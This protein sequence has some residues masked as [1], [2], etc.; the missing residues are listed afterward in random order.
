MGNLSAKYK[1]LKCLVGGNREKTGYEDTFGMPKEEFWKITMPNK[2]IRRALAQ[3]EFAIRLSRQLNGRYHDDVEAA[4][5]YMQAQIDRDGVLTR[6]TCEKAEVFLLPLAEEAKA[7]SLILAAHAHIDMNWM[8]SW[9]ETVAATIATFQ[10][11]LQLLEEYPDFCF[12][13]S[14]ASVYQIVEK[15]APELKEKIQRY[16]QEGR[17][18][19]TASAWVETDK[20]M[21]STES[22]LNHIYYTKKYMQENWGIPPESLNI[23][24][25]PDTFGH[26][27]NLPELD[28][29]G[30]VDYYYHCRGLDGDNALYRWRAPSGKEMIVYREQYW[31]NS[32]ITPAPGIGIIDVANRSGGL[33]TGLVVY[34][35]GDHGGGPTRRDLERAL[36]MM[37]WPVFPAVRFGTI[38]EFFK[39]AE[40]V[41][42]LLPLLD[43]ELNFIMPGCYTTQSRLKMANRRTEAALFDAQ[44]WDT[45]AKGRGVSASDESQFASA[46]QN[47][48]FTH[49]H[50]I[51]TGSCVQDTREHAM[52][53][54]SEATA[55]AE[56]RA[57]LALQGIAGLIDTSD[58]AVI[59]QGGNQAD[60][61]GAG[62]GVE[63]F[64]GV[65]APERG[66]GLTRIYHLFNSASAAREEA[67]EITVWD[68][69]GDMREIVFT[70]PHGEPLAFQLLDSSL[71]QYWDHKYFRVLVYV[72]IP[73]FGY[74][75]V[76][77]AEKEPEE[78]R[79]YFQPEERSNKPT[80]DM[81]LQNEHLRAVFCHRTGELLSLVDNLTGEEQVRPGLSGGLRL[82]QTEKA[83]SN[84]W[85]IG[86]YESTTGPL[87]T[88]GIKPFA[89]E[90][91]SGFELKQ[92]V[93]SSEITTVV[94]LSE[95]AKALAL[96]ITADWHEITGETVPVLI[97]TVPVRDTQSFLYDVPGGA[98]R[99]DAMELDVPGLQYAAAL[100]GE[101]AL[102][103]VSD[104]KYGY[105]GT[106]DSLS[107]TLINATYS[108][109]P[110]PE[111]GIHKIKLFLGMQKSCPKVL[112]EM[113]FCLNH[114]VPYQSGCKKTGPLGKTGALLQAE[115]GT[116]VL[117][118]ISMRDGFITVRLY[119]TCGETAIV[120]LASDRIDCS[121]AVLCDL[122]GRPVN[123]SLTAAE[124][125]IS[126]VMEPNSTKM[127]RIPLP[128]RA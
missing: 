59:P 35:V 98:Q 74:T 4:L 90:L 115:L 89:G 50:D 56:S 75:T 65:P 31:Y 27:A 116:A 66:Q 2:Y 85:Q 49:F 38:G 88:V 125:C 96:D 61:A 48:L 105:R 21:P 107:C 104:C 123:G 81:V 122:M 124:D 22:L 46:W 51:L 17:W 94:S 87:Q 126:L 30:G 39:E 95:N 67:C 100:H 69:T 113:A 14:Q 93:Q 57:S 24:F 13:Q 92:K 32:G 1:A 70:G 99:R 5:D 103:L 114:P 79:I 3:T 11:M 6:E 121:G 78:Y 109:D 71:Q 63:A 7:Y 36:E 101:R 73:A 117:S 80:E 15:Y 41:R 83:S 106:A 26:S 62:F 72:K 120:Q 20:N 127:I 12:S 44:V 18:E 76:V 64:S 119:E 86:R 128:E 118:G 10:T 42:E 9:H 19:V 82:V 110:Y 55:V 16:I 23:D 111:R 58:I 28:A 34:G 68:W 45:L 91:K 43:R 108:P 84:A 60:G 112:E 54:F 53:L 33:K 102:T 77:L 37:E 29:L 40:G 8:W 25:S 97:Y 47:V 52:G